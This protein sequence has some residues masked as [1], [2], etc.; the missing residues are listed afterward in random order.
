MMWLGKRF[1]DGGVTT[2]GGPAVRHRCCRFASRPGGP[3]GDVW[4]INAD[5]RNQVTQRKL[6]CG[7]G[8]AQTGGNLGM[9]RGHRRKQKPGQQGDSGPG[10]GAAVEGGFRQ[11]DARHGGPTQRVRNRQ[12]S[13][14]QKSGAPKW[15]KGTASWER[16]PA[17]V[18]WS[19]NDFSFRN[20]KTGFW[21]GEHQGT[22]FKIQYG[23]SH[24][25]RWPVISC[26]KVDVGW[27]PHNNKKYSGFSPGWKGGGQGFFSQDL[28]YNF[29]F[30]RGADRA[31]PQDRSGDF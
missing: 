3:A 22:H 28:L 9:G 5:R 1:A 8:V 23:R 19:A 27:E 21:A 15:S 24:C 31:G 12:I 17:H 10:G 18:T 29:S 13:G 7:T 25:R 26:R 20:K 30:H 16:K 4:S 2:D 14:S 11:S 6:A